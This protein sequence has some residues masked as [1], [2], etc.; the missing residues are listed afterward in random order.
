[1]KKFKVN[2]ISNKLFKNQPSL[3][4]PNVSSGAYYSFCTVVPFFFSTGFLKPLTTSSIL[5]S[6]QEAS[7]AD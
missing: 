3:A 2:W 7:I 5:K 6:M 4:S 1:M